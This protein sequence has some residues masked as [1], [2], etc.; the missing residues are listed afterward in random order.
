MVRKESKVDVSNCHLLLDVVRYSQL[1]SLGSS[2]WHT[3]W[4]GT[5]RNFAGAEPNSSS[6]SLIKPAG[7]LFGAHR[8][9]CPR[10]V[11]TKLTVYHI[12]R[13]AHVAT[14]VAA[15]LETNLILKWT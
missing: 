3:H 6:F 8:I 12:Q 10:E 13:N 7:F 9:F 15:F 14:K 1:Y 5:V 11:G 2:G 4:P